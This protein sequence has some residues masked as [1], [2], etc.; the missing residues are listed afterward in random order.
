[1]TLCYIILLLCAALGYITYGLTATLCPNQETNLAYSAIVNGERLPM[2]RSDVRVFGRVYDLDVMK[3]FFAQQGLN[4]TND[5]ENMD[6]SSIFNG[7]ITGSC[8]KFDT[9][10]STSLGDCTLYSPYGNSYILYI[11]I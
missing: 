7:D 1:M 2:W 11:Y 9:T 8:K 4:L 6:I 3:S 5:Y 10:S